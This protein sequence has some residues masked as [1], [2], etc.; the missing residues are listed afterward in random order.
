MRKILKEKSNEKKKVNVD[1]KSSS[2]EGI[3]LKEQ[4]VSKQTEES[5]NRGAIQEAECDGCVDKARNQNEQLNQ[6]F[7]D[8]DI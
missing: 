4:K 3:G 5:R 1:E 8:L 6:C 2:Q 7:H